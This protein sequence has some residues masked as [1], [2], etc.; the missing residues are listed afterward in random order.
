MSAITSA[1][2]FSSDGT[3]LIIDKPISSVSIN[4]TDDTYINNNHITPIGS[5]LTYAG[6]TAPQ[7]W[8][9]CD[10]SEVNKTIY[11]RL[12]SVI[13]NN[14]GSPVNSN[15]F[16][17]PNLEQ[18]IPVGKSNS[19]TLGSTGGSDNVTLSTSQLPSHNH[20][21]TTNNDG[22]HSH[23]ITD[24]G[25]AH[26]QWTRQDDYNEWGGNPPSFTDDAGSTVT[27]SNINSSTTGISIN[28]N[29]TH[30]HTF[31]T[32][33]TGSGSSI[34]IRNKFIILNYIIRY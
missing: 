24:P 11:S 4:L 19:T 31:T 29:G 16:V 28:A 34:D 2:S 20:S 10:G 22:S 13:G 17:L 18:R 14:Y 23:S 1:V 32:G 12:F 5:I 30:N 9:L 21:G 26:T 3:N 25:H 6:S 33:N 8:L 7:G 27:W 15:N